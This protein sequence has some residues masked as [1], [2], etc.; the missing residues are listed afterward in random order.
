M[1]NRKLLF[2]TRTFSNFIMFTITHSNWL[3][4]SHT[5][6]IN[7]QGTDVYLM[8]MSFIKY[9]IWKL[10]DCPDCDDP[11]L[12]TRWVIFWINEIIGQIP[13]GKGFGRFSMHL[14]Y[15]N[16]LGATDVHQSLYH[17]RLLSL[18][19]GTPHIN[20]G[21]RIK[22]VS[23]DRSVSPST[24]TTLIFREDGCWPSHSN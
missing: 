5:V 15:D 1:I 16:R 6:F 20:T 22:S 9:R 18:N 11:P 10:Q 14:E 23:S 17:R 12:R 19:I 24:E 8:T 2:L 4:V 3:N 21:K 13:T 7:T